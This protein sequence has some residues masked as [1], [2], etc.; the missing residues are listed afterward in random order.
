VYSKPY[1]VISCDFLKGVGMAWVF[2]DPIINLQ[3][4]RLFK[5]GL[6]A[7]FSHKVAVLRFDV[8]RTSISP[9]IEGSAH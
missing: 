1:S 6:A 3:I 5:L 2:D 9:L 8:W 4:L 7:Q